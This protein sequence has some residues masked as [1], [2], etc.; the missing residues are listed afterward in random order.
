MTLRSSFA[1]MDGNIVDA[2]RFQPNWPQV[3][4]LRADL[5]EKAPHESGMYLR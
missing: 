4:H 1:V 2:V 5:S 3:V